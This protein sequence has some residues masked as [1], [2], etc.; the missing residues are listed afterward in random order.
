MCIQIALLYFL[1]LFEDF[2]LLHALLHICYLNISPLYYVL[3]AEQVVNMSKNGVRVATI[4]F[5]NFSDMSKQQPSAVAATAKSP[6]V[7][8]PK[9]T[10]WQRKQQQKKG[11]GK[12]R[13]W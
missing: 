2:G 3:I 10:S 12:G 7:E 8:A 4:F 5:F 9:E 6:R 11:K 1:S 13:K